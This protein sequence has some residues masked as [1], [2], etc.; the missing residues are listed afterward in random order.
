MWIFPSRSQWGS[1]S[2]PSKL[3]AIG[4]YVGILSIVLT[5]AMFAI[6]TYR[7][8]SISAQSVL[9]RTEPPVASD[10]SR[11]TPSN[12]NVNPSEPPQ[13]PQSVLENREVSPRGTAV[14]DETSALGSPKTPLF[15]SPDDLTR[16]YANP[17]FTQF[18]SDALLAPYLGKWLVVSGTVGDISAS[19]RE[20]PTVYLNLKNSRTRFV[21]L[22][23]RGSEQASAVFLLSKGNRIKAIG[24]ITA[25]TTDFIIL[26]HC[27]LL[28]E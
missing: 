26:D 18:Q 10:D 25:A 13:G 21:A 8:R 16:F 28:S 4:A 15:I 1:W 7:E 6:Q 14:D 5:V 12:S 9:E 2:L 17:E 20:E 24:A 19:K 23:F 22:N 11:V 27:E 3:T